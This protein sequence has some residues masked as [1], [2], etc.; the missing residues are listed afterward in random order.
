V[1]TVIVRAQVPI[2][3]RTNRQNDRETGESQFTVARVY[4]Q[5]TY[6]S[7]QKECE[8]LIQCPFGPHSFGDV[9][10]HMGNNADRQ[11]NRQREKNRRKQ[12]Q[13]KRDSQ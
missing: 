6:K 13:G 10:E 11:T 7:E 8:I 12:K 4:E 1:S 9:H 2:D 5:L 3:R